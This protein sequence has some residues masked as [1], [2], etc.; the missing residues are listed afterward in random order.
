VIPDHLKIQPGQEALMPEQEAEARRFAAE[1]VAAHLSTEPVDEAEAERL[2][3]EA[4]AVAG[5]PAPRRIHWLDG[6][7]PF[8]AALGPHSL[9][10]IV[11]ASTG[12]RVEASIEASIETGVGNGVRQHIRASIDASLK[13]SVHPHLRASI[14]M[15]LRDHLTQGVRGSIRASV[16]AVLGASSFE[17]SLGTGLRPSLRAS[18]DAGLSECI[19]VCID[20]RVWE[21]LRPTF[22]HY[23]SDEDGLWSSVADSLW[24]YHEAGWLACAR[25]FDVYQAPNAGHAFSHF[26]ELVSGY[27]LGKVAAVLVRRPRVLARDQAS[28]LHNARGKCLEYRDGWG[29][30]AWHGVRVPE[31]II[32]MPEKLTRDDFLPEQNVEVRRVIQER[33]GERFVSELGGVVLDRSPRG[34]LYEVRLPE[35][36]PERVARYVQ[37]QDASTDRQYFLRVPPTIQAAAEAVAW[38]FQVGVEDYHPAQET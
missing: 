38:T 32:L 29:F 5:L 25:F 10:A 15:S 11:K 28:R 34:T 6:P 23:G 24:A 27:W 33:M 17:T 36:D 16:E 22:D 4:Y 13:A 3:R 18:I 35:D 37:V 7:L 26:N 30:Y 19:R 9:R 20:A 8:V 31:Q 1:R 21:R 2:L 12:A 14:E